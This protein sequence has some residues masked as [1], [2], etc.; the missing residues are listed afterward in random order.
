MNTQCGNE[1]YQK[2]ATLLLLFALLA[3]MLYQSSLDGQC[4]KYH[5]DG[6]RWSLVGVYCWRDLRGMFREYYRLDD[7]REKHEGPKVDPTIRPTPGA[8]I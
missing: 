5:A 6:A 2:I 4:M 8:D 1:R 7:L 3:A